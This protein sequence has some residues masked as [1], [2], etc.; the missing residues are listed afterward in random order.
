MPTLTYGVAA[1]LTGFLFALYKLGALQSVS[2]RQPKYNILAMVWLDRT[3]LSAYLLTCV[4]SYSFLILSKN[5]DYLDLE[6]LRSR[7]GKFYMAYFGRQDLDSGR[8][9]AST[10]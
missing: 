3:C 4:L 2:P 9:K 5:G 6:K 7:F 8:T 1:L 10:F